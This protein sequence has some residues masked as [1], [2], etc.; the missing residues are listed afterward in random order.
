MDHTFAGGALF[1]CTDGIWSQVSTT[2]DFAFR[3]NGAKFLKQRVELLLN[4]ASLNG[5][6][7]QLTFIFKSIIPAGTTINFEIQPTGQSEWFPLDARDPSVIAN[8][9]PQVLIRAV[10]NGTVDVMPGMVLDTD[11][12]V[13]AGRMNQTMQAVSGLLSRGFATE[14]VEV[15]YNVDNFDAARH[16][17]VP[18]LL[19]ND[20][21]VNPASV[22][23]IP[24]PTKESRGKYKAVFDF[25]GAAISDLRLRVDQTTDSYT[26]VPFGQDVQINAF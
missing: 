9:P 15:I 22:T 12:R 11:A 20:A 14:T 4:P 18:K 21:P 19:V 23:P 16:T 3:L 1:V 24:D 6:L 26:K 8:L 5:G 10:F 2:E 7:T 25:T 17:V 13:V